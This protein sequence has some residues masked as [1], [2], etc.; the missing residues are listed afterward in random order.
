[1]D[2]PGLVPIF[3]LGLVAFPGMGLP[4]HI[5]EDRYRTLVRDLLAKEPPNDRVF[6]IVAIREGY[7]VGSHEARS[8]YRVGCLMRLVQ[9]EPYA[10]GRFDIASVGVRRLR[11]VETDTAA[12]YLRAR[13]ELL[14]AGADAPEEAAR[15][16]A[17]ALAAFADYRRVVSLLR[18]DDVMS[19]DLPRDPEQ[20]SYAL[21][22]TCSLTL[23]E[24]QQLLEQ[25]STTDRLHLLRRQ[26]SAELRAIRA[27]PSLPATEVARSGWSP[28]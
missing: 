20:L 14:P 16:A 17:L 12:S 3:P 9:A 23:S 2:S 4:L 11:V 5:F 13:V 1:M 15:S 6:G 27:I 22:A 24:R 28:N 8:M 25:P 26:L 10:D 19:G 21:A 18:D 7:E